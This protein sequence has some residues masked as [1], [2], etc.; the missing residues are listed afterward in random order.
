MKLNRVLHQSLCLRNGI[1][2][3]DPHEHVDLAKDP[4]SASQLEALLSMYNAEVNLF[5]NTS[6]DLRG[7][8][9]AVVRRGGYMGP[10]LG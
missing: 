10:W 8:N 3:S 7:F 5:E 6:K 1:V 9:A 2:T 4:R